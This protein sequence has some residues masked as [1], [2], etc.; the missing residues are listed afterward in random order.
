MRVEQRMVL[1]GIGCAAI[2]AGI[3]AWIAGVDRW[4]K[5]P[6]AAPDAVDGSTRSGE[7]AGLKAVE[8][9][10]GPEAFPDPNAPGTAA[11]V[12]VNRSYLD[13][14]IFN[15]ALPFTG[16]I[17]DYNS[18]SELGAA[19]RG[20]GG[21]GLAALLGQY[22]QLRIDSPPSP[23][24]AAQAIRLQRSIAFLY[25]HE[26]KL[27]E[28]ATWL[29]R[30]LELSRKRGASLDDQ[31]GLRALLGIAALRRG[32]IENC[33]GCTGPSSCI[34]P[35]DRRA[36][37]VHQA[38]SR[39][40]VKHLAAALELTPGDLRLRW[41]LN[42][43]SMTL[44]EYPDKVPPAYRIAPD[45]FRSKL[46]VGHFENVAQRVGL[47]VRGPN[48]AG[49]SI[50][51]DLNGD[52]LPDLFTTSIDGDLGA[53]LYLNRGNGTFE[54]RSVAA[55]LKEQVYVLN[56]AAADFDND[57]DLDI[58]LMRG[59]WESPARL[60]LLR[61]KGIG[62]FEDV[63]VASGLDEP[64]STESAVWGDYDNDGLVDL[65]V[66]GEFHGDP[67]DPRNR[68]RLYHNEGDGKFRNVAESAG[69]ANERLAKGSA[70]GDYDGDGRLD[71]FVS[72]LDG[73]S[74]LYHNEGGGRFRDVAAEVG[75]TGP[76]HYHS[77]ACWFWDFDN[78]GRLDLFVNDYNPTL[79]D[80]VARHL[81]LKAKDAG[82][83]HLYRNLGPEGFRD[84]SE[85]V[86]LDWPIPAM[87]ANFGDIDND[88]Y[89][90]AYFGTGWMSYSG[91]VPNVMLK[92]V[93]GRRFEDVT[94]STRTGHLQK[95]HGISFADWDCDGDL[96]VFVVLGGGYPGDQAFNVLFQ[97]PGHGHHWLKIKLVGT[98]TNRSALGAGIRVELKRPDGASQLIHRIIGNNGSF[99]GNPLTQT[100]GLG[101][102]KTV[103]RLTVSWPATGMTQ[104]FQD[105]AADQAIVITEGA[106]TFK[107]LRQPPLPLPPPR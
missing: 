36:V 65:F 11:R 57:G 16:E 84:V 58:V 38:G 19:I 14:E 43:V 89:L 7:S 40:A 72:N 20:R 46:D 56:V 83:P 99:G 79:A 21:R 18:L 55:G 49:G 8:R 33:L 66:C 68:C 15:T 85:A 101:N 107:V 74:R 53:S 10:T 81:G 82:H 9:P 54:D 71:L 92:N 80:V 34:F 1:V 98:K 31:A 104:T 75:V 45:S 93:E 103:A 37:H 44:G 64:L 87:G 4:G 27:A 48:Q 95:G 67:P 39:E 12:Y 42:I 13:A 77:F 62:V 5:A 2:G 106:N 61:N 94:G 32:E 69:V 6:S 78:D 59:A 86:G 30:A 22:D 52:D 91:L 50:F 26:G 88:G 102:A 76:S 23:D 17:Q 47:D 3:V 28:A 51:D 63:T 100:I 70:W 96:D 25:M 41:L 105:V 24:Q 29:E 73:P 90:D 35:I 60:T 97:N